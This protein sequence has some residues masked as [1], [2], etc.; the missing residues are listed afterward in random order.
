VLNANRPS[1]FHREN[2]I[3]DF[4]SICTLCFK[5]VGTE[6]AE[7]DLDAHE[8]IHL[9]VAGAFYRCG[10]GGGLFSGFEARFVPFWGFPYRER[11][12]FYQMRIMYQ[13]RTRRR[14]T[15]TCQ[16]PLRRLQHI[17]SSWRDFEARPS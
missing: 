7:I 13:I 2:L 5:T 3:G 12:T 14:K 11:G 15:S 8:L 16:L 17:G 6:D 4:D 9:R 1:L 10:E